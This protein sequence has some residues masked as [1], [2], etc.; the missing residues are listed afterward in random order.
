MDNNNNKIITFGCRLNS[1]ESEVIKGSL[2]SAKLN[3]IVLFNTCTVTKEAERQG[4]QAIRK[5]RKEY[6]NHK[7]IVT[8]CAVQVNPEKYAKL[9]EVDKVIGNEEKLSKDLFKSD[10]LISEE[11]IKVNDI[12]SIKETAGHIVSSFDGKSRAFVQVQNGCNHRCTFCTIPYGRGNSRS[13]APGEVVAQVKA[14]VESGYNEIVITGVDI[15]DYG[16][17]LETKPNL[18]QLIKRILKLVPQLKRIRLSSIDVAEIDNDLLELIKY[19]PRL[20]PHLHISLQAGDNLILKR[21]KRRHN[22]EQVIEFCNFVREYRKNIAFGADIIAGFPTESEEMFEN[23]R[24]LIQEACIQFLHVFP[25]SEREGT[26]AARM[27]QVEKKIRKERA[28]IL[29]QEGENQLEKFIGSHFQQQCSVIVEKDNWT[30]AENFISVKVDGQFN[31]GDV[32][33][34]KVVGVEK[35]HAIGAKI[36]QV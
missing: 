19:E 4:L 1:Y 25:Y 14:L 21:M 18:G 2:E 34:I 24:K 6:P 29:R 26:P 13:V 32:F 30:K 5:A 12:M 27:P 22:R 3:N 23:T 7:I 28:S 16:L 10:F 36:I 8:G 31:S 9:K 15:T 33:P 20:M 35:G 11:K 17:D